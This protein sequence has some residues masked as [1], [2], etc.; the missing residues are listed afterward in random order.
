ME[1]PPPPVAPPPPDQSPNAAALGYTKA[2]TILAWA[3]VPPVGSFVM[4]FLAG[5]DAVDARF[6]AAN[7]TAVHGLMLAVYFVLWI[8]TQA[9]GVFVVL[10]WLWGFLWFSVWLIGVVMAAQSEG[11][12]FRFP[13]LTDTLAG[14]IPTLE[15]LT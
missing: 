11:R 4:V 12:R 6:N 3:L 7:A 5:K 9:I 8:L 15:N 10:L 1:E 2:F 14:V 13:V